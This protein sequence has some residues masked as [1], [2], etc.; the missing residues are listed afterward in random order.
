MPSTTT[1]TPLKRGKLYWFFHDTLVI[2]KRSLL[3]V[4]ADPEQLLGITLQPIMFVVLF[5]YVFG[6]AIN[7]G[8]ESYIN[9]LMAGIF[10]Q[11]ITFGA[12]ITG[13][14]IA[15]DLQRGIMDRF[16][17]LPMNKSAILTGTVISDM[18]KNC[19]AIFVMIVTGLI[20]GFR[21]D[22]DIMGWL[23][24]LGLLILF[25]FAISWVFAIVGMKGKTIEF[26]QQMGFLVLFPLTFVS[27]TFVPTST[28][29]AGLRPFAEN[30][31]LT[32]MAEAV[33]ALLLNNPVGNHGWLA[34]AWSLG[35][36][37]VAVP[38]AISLFKKQGK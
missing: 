9:F 5:R 15:S 13:L 27:S 23:A 1:V 7:T 26:V 24:A 29:P 3:H 19:L 16:R 28:M 38:I 34:L 12:S 37:L 30:Q 21:P 4:K 35:I 6:G 10:V 22:A 31:P 18:I 17:S 36:L 8:G 14:T 2:M 32:H 33:R 25:S 11:T 20:V